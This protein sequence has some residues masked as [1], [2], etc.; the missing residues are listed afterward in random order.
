MT[1]KDAL[2]EQLFPKT[3]DFIGSEIQEQKMIIS[4]KSNTKSVACPKCNHVS[5]A[6]HSTKTRVCQD[7]PISSYATELHIECG[8][9]RCENES[10]SKKFFRETFPE[11]IKPMSRRT[12][13]LDEE[14]FKLA[15]VH[16]SE[17]TARDLDAI[18][19]FS[20]S[21]DTI[22]RLIRRKGLIQ[23]DYESVVAVG[24]DDFCTK[25]DQNTER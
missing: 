15:I 23:I 21:G 25:K 12:V 20:I 3:F 6:K 9:Y 22:L 17:Q 16:S 7:L 11:F 10:C 8:T 4:L 13:R 1:M 5:I 14:I 18:M 19:H 2:V 24:I